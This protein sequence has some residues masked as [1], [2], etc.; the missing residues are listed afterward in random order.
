MCCPMVAALMCEILIGHTQAEALDYPWCTCHVYMHVL[1][2]TAAV[3]NTQ[4]RVIHGLMW[5]SFQGD[6]DPCLQLSYSQ[7]GQIKF[8]SNFISNLRV[9]IVNLFEWLY[10]KSIIV[11]QY[12]ELNIDI[13]CMCEW[14]G[15]FVLCADGRSQTAPVK[16]CSGLSPSTSSTGWTS[17][18]TGPR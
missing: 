1:T 5:Y 7:C 15:P 16:G 10:N 18:K 2:F 12:F 4:T 6:K 9:D 8:T 13:N 3:R 17:C 14:H 11:I